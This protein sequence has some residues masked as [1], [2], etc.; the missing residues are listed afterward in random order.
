MLTLRQWKQE[1]AE[2]YRPGEYNE[3][4]PVSAAKFI[5]K[6]SKPDVVFEDEGS[7]FVGN[8]NIR[9]V[10]YNSINDVIQGKNRVTNI[11]VYPA[12]REVCYEGR[13][14]VRHEIVGT[15]SDYDK[16][17]SILKDKVVDMQ[18]IDY[19]DASMYYSSRS[20][21]KADQDLAKKLQKRYGGTLDF[22][23]SSFAE[24]N[25]VMWQGTMKSLALDAGFPI[26][27]KYCYLSAD[28]KHKISI[29]GQSGNYNL[30]V[31][32]KSTDADNFDYDNIYQQMNAIDDNSSL[33]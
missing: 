2:Y 3:V 29:T 8:G 32:S 4:T 25:G 1:N 31:Y 16:I 10:M 26:R 13:G 14:S 15:E 19:E 21:W 6:I 28:K 12:D 20:K 22:Y 33:S 5:E 17:V 18:T 24:V 9:Y 27:G 11:D 23:G 7:H 30:F